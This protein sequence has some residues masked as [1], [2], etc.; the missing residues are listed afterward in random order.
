[1]VVEFGEGIRSL[2]ISSFPT[3]KNNS[4]RIL[5]VLITYFV[6]TIVERYQQ[7]AC[8]TRRLNEIRLRLIALLPFASVS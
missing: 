5:I 7:R 8:N 6:R 4:S 3:Y 2:D 1:M